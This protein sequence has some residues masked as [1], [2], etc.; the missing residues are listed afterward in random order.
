MAWGGGYWLLQGQ[1]YRCTFCSAA[2]SK[3][4]EGYRKS[5]RN[6]LTV[7]KLKLGPK[8]QTDS[9]VTFSCHSA[10]VQLCRTP[11]SGAATSGVQLC[12]R[13]QHGCPQPQ[14]RSGR[15]GGGLRVKVLW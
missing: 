6:R 15:V 11:P 10:S 13:R 1:I 14:A 12:Y 7:F 9:E 5:T 3:Q 4:P 2:S 8:L